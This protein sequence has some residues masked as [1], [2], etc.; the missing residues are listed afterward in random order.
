MC[1]CVLSVFGEGGRETQKGGAGNES[2]RGDLGCRRCAHWLSHENGMRV[3]SSQGPVRW[4][5]RGKK[6][7]VQ[8][9]VQTGKRSLAQRR[10]MKRNGT[11]KT[12]MRELERI[13]PWKGLDLDGRKG[14]S[15]GRGTNKDLTSAS[16]ARRRWENGKWQSQPVQCSLP[17][18]WSRCPPR[19]TNRVPKQRK[20]TL[21]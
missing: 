10:V 14:W 17:C 12:E 4:R 2:K 18:W 11:R 16:A 9:F 6:L 21:R 15:L 13:R 5:R 19:H 7:N 8:K 20:A 3:Q 1:V